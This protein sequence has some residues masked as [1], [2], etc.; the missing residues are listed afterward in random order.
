MATYCLESGPEEFSSAIIHELDCSS[1]DL[2]SLLGAGRLVSLGE[3]ENATVALDAVKAH[4]PDAVRCVNCCHAAM[5]LPMHGPG[6]KLL[7]LVA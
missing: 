2:G 6:R 1:Y 5:V 3:F 7:N 4:H